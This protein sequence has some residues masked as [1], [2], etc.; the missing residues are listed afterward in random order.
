MNSDL[1]PDNYNKINLWV[2]REG[3]CK[4]D[5]CRNFKSRQGNE[6]KQIRGRGLRERMEKVSENSMYWKT[7]GDGYL[8]YKLVIF[9]LF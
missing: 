8:W 5:G 1:N 6:G 9:N 2:G 7:F 4:Q 3:N